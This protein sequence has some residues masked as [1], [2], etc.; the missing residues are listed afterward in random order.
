MSQ[1]TSNGSPVKCQDMGLGSPVFVAQVAEYRESAVA[2]SRA[3]QTEAN[4]M[5]Y[6]IKRR[7]MKP[8]PSM[9]THAVC[10]TN[11]WYI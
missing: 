10:G 2:E 4:K 7:R 9:P 11:L 5:Q 6:A 1:N 3:V 8:L